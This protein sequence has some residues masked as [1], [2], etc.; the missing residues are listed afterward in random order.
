MTGLHLG[1]E[2][3]YSVKM[4]DDGDFVAAGAPGMCGGIL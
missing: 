2:L 3:G 4:S 1:S